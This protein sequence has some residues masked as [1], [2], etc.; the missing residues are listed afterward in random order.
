MVIVVVLPFF[1]LPVE[2]VNV[3][4]D[5][6]TVEELVELLIVDPMRSFDFAIQ[7][8]GPRPDVHVPDVACFEMPVEVGLEFGAIVGLNDMDAE[9]QSPEDV[10]DECDRRP[11]IAGIVDLQYANVGAICR[12]SFGKSR[13]AGRS[14]PRCQRLSPRAA[15][16]SASGSNRLCSEFV[17]G[18]PL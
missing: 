12:T 6:V 10:I 1:Q 4:G 18:S 9:G 3:V 14:G 13:S 8:W 17:I 16:S 2:E 15:S 5:A 7:V 11:L